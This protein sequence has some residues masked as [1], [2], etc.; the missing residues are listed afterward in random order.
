VPLL[1]P[2]LQ[3]Q[4][5]LFLVQLQPASLQQPELRLHQPQ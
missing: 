1:Q 3:L 2:L 5:P 4:P